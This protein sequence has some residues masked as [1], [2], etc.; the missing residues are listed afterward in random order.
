MRTA[1][2]DADE[3]VVDPLTVRA[4]APVGI[5]ARGPR[6]SASRSSSLMSGSDCSLGRPAVVA[7][8][9]AEAAAAAAGSGG[10]GGD[11]DRGIIGELP[12]MN[13]L[14]PDRSSECVRW[15]FWRW[16]IW[17]SGG[18]VGSTSDC[19]ELIDSC[20]WCM[21]RRRRRRGGV[22]VLRSE[23]DTAAAL[24]QLG[25]GAR[26]HGSATGC[27]DRGSRVEVRNRGSNGTATHSQ[28]SRDGAL[29]KSDPPGNSTQEAQKTKRLML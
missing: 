21:V 14:N 4:G 10:V 16:V 28:R 27:E 11:N 18:V 3:D 25:G 8:A 1:D 6:P 26:G 22:G 24:S 15:W 2:A 19:T 7:E 13:W 9:E 20:G 17:P 29:A 23:G 5:G 12:C